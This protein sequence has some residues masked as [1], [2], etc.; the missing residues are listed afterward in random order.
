M[1]RG[2]SDGGLPPDD[3]VQDEKS[4]LE[5]SERIIDAFHDESKF[6]MT[7]VFLAPCSPFSVT[8]ELMKDAAVLARD[9]GVHL[10]THLCETIDEEEYALKEYGKR[11]YDLMEELGWVGDDVWYAHGI[12]FNDDEIKRIGQSRTGVAHCPTSNMRL[13]SGIAR[14]PDLL[15]AGARVGLAVD[16]SA[17][18]D[19]SNMLRELKHTMLVHRIGT[20]VT[21]MGAYEVLKMATRGGAEILG[22]DDIGSL[23]VGKAADIVMFDMN[24]LD[25]VGGMHD[26]LAALLFCGTEDRADTVI[27]NGEIKV[28]DKKLVPISEEKLIEEASK[29]AKSIIS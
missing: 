3:T 23:E 5:D 11:P 7:R 27:V 24:K 21:A 17:S 13:G 29:E 28:Q 2:K 10:H 18:A 15:K 4:I 25:Y 6:S 1:S 20:D 14:I 26:P 9:K 22:R 16:G 12:Y 8:T 19:S